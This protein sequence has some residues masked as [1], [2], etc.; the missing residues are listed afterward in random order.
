MGRTLTVVAA[1]PNDGNTY[2]EDPNVEDILKALRPFESDAHRIERA[3]SISRLAKV[4]RAD[5]K[6]SG[7]PD[8][9]QIL[10]HGRPGILFL[11]ASWTGSLHGPKGTYVLDGN[12]YDY[13]VLDKCVRAPTHVY[14]LGCEV[15]T[16]ARTSEVADGVSLLF[17]L[18]RMWECKVSAPEDLVMPDDF[19]EGVYAKTETLATAEGLLVRR[20]PQAKGAGAPKKRGIGA[21][22]R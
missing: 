11:A 7:P 20:P 1:P 8:L 4:L 15:G 10:G 5:L 21:P 14:L 6:A 19:E 16:M 22:R 18:S 2:P 9:V 12:P 13:G 3:W 17:D